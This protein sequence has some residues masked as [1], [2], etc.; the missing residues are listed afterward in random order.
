MTAG[1]ILE[2]FPSIKTVTIVVRK[3]TPRASNLIERLRKEAPS[4]EI[5]AVAGDEASEVVRQADIICTSVRLRFLLK[6]ECL[7]TYTSP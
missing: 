6:R 2:L 7:L 1:L 5:D 4:V 3:T